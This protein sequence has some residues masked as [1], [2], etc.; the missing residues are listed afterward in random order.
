MQNKGTVLCRLRT[1]YF[2][3]S[4]FVISYCL[5]CSFNSYCYFLFLYF[6]FHTQLMSLVGAYLLVVGQPGT[7]AVHNI[8]YW[9]R[10]R[11]Y[12]RTAHRRSRP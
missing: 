1:A 4:L 9:S 8:G 12:S 11:S 10:R 3:R 7:S 6:L 5:L 2:I